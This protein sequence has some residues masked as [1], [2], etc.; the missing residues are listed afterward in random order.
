MVKFERTFK[1]GERTTVNTGFCDFLAVLTK[2]DM[3]SITIADNPEDEIGN[4]R[5]KLLQLSI[6]LE[7]ELQ[8]DTLGQK[9][10]DHLERAISRIASL[11]HT[12]DR[13]Y[14]HKST[15]NFKDEKAFR[16]V[17]LLVIC[18]E[19]QIQTQ[20]TL[21]EE[22][23]RKNLPK[24]VD[25]VTLEYY[26]LL[27]KVFFNPAL[28]L[29]NRELNLAEVSN[30][31]VDD[32]LAFAEFVFDGPKHSEQF[33]LPTEFIDN[34]SLFL[35]LW[36]NR[37]GTLQ[38]DVLLTN[39]PADYSQELIA[40]ARTT[41]YDID[42][43]KILSTLEPL[44][45]SI[46]DYRYQLSQDILLPTEVGEAVR[47]KVSEALQRLIYPLDFLFDIGIHTPQDAKAYYSQ[48]VASSS[49]PQFSAESAGVF[50]ELEDVLYSAVFDNH[51]EP[52]VTVSQFVDPNRPATETTTN[53]Q[54]PDEFLQTCADQFKFIQ[55]Y[56][57]P[58]LWTFYKSQIFATHHPFV[59]INTVQ[60]TLNTKKQLIVE[61]E[62]EN[63]HRLFIVA[64]DTKHGGFEWQLLEDPFTDEET[65]QFY[66]YVQSIISDT[67]IQV[68]QTVLTDQE[69]KQRAKGK[70]PITNQPTQPK[71]ID[72]E[73]RR[74]KF[75]KY[76]P[77]I[78]EPVSGT[79]GLESSADRTPAIV[80]KLVYTD[81][82]V[83]TACKLGGI[84]N[85]RIIEDK[86]VYLSRLKENPLLFRPE[87][88]ITFVFNGKKCK[89]CKLGKD[90][91]V[92][93]TSNDTVT[94]GC[95]EYSIVIIGHRS[96]IY[97]M[98]GA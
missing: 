62:F 1:T 6:H 59:P 39:D 32:A 17:S 84:K 37:V 31:E 73:S 56:S 82:E 10:K 93:V 79:L 66:Y 72:A 9:I 28:Q 94:P 87:N 4:Q 29:F 91:R 58:K 33:H 20:L 90:Y 35:Q 47:E 92:V 50:H 24:D 71:K 85:K 8:F 5:N 12:V 45:T 77:A 53:N 36:G 18:A 26:F 98:L 60:L 34:Y 41:R 52:L 42:L 83:E 22:S 70:T 88:L 49:D 43:K 74:G 15:I 75:E 23:V 57:R 96:A 19:L 51:F 27:M 95:A 40:L 44:F 86:R 46:K 13:L 61:M 69:I 64:I 3:R 78:K 7:K 81:V 2:I 21:N 11:I 76:R 63:I 97:K 68:F 14:K 38:S 54:N 30:H 89:K 16:A 80:N 25:A 65:K 67:L 55:S 48:L